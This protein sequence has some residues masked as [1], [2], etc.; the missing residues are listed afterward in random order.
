MEPE[1]S[2][3]HSQV[4]VTCSYLERDRSNPRPYIP[5]AEDQSQNYPRIHTWFFQVVSFLLDSSQSP[6]YTSPLHTHATCPT[7]FILLD[8][9]T[10]KIMGGGVQNIKLLI[11][12][13]QKNTT[14]RDKLIY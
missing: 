12:Y 6:V 2:L 4:S 10:R 14:Y 8:L 11:L 9:I 1:C 13:F 7:H 5:F 3:P